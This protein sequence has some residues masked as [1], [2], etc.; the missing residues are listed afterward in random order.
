M[1]EISLDRCR[2]IEISILERFDNICRDNKLTYFV[3]YGTLLG[4]VRHKG[5]IPW[6]DDIDV[7]MPRNDY[8]QFAEVIGEKDSDLLFIRP[9]NCKDTIYP[10]GKLVDRRTHMTVNGFKSVA[11][12]GVNIDVFPLDYLLEDSRGRNASRKKALFLKKI[13]ENSARNIAP[14]AF[15]LPSR[16]KK[17][18]IYIVSRFISTRAM[19]HI[20]NTINV[21]NDKTNYMGIAWEKEI[22]VDKLFQPK[23]YDFEG[24][25]V[26][27]PNDAV[28]CL[29]SLYGEY[30]KLPPESERVRKHNYKCYWK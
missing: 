2:N 20:L 24:L 22:P 15:S 30:M 3:Y 28:F 17:S 21:Q 12:Y 29:T 13:I 4:A 14:K 1:E 25:R 7:V 9:E 11:D 8:D 27:G 5:F 26:M 6:D 10:H 23:D 18:L 19:I 16:I